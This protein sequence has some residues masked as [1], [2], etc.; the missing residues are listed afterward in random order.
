MTVSA[1]WHKNTETFKLTGSSNMSVHD[2]WHTCHPTHTVSDVVCV[3]PVWGRFD[4]TV[5]GTCMVRVEQVDESTSFLP[6]AGFLTACP[7]SHR[8]GFLLG[9]WQHRVAPLKPHLAQEEVD[10]AGPHQEAQGEG[11][12]GARALH[13][14][15]VIS[16]STWKNHIRRVWWA[17]KPEILCSLIP[18]LSWYYINFASVPY[19]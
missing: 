13:G 14:D 12:S 3:S 15:P 16:R 17:D 11:P 18:L 2:P 1:G 19:L 6:P 7:L 10:A 8:C 9:L 4:K 5:S